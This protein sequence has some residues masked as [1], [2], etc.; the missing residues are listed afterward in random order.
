MFFLFNW[1]LEMVQCRAAKFAKSRYKRTNS[2]TAMLEELGWPILSKSAQGRGLILFNKII[3]NLAQDV[4]HEH[5]LTKA[6]KGTRK[7]IQLQI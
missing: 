7:K 2:V 6:C 5:I 3:K 1:K 4:P